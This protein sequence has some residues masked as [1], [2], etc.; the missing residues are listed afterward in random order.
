MA[1]DVE[2]E[3]REVASALER[4]EAVEG[5]SWTWREDAPEDVRENPPLGVVAQDLEKVFPELVSTR[6]DGFKQIN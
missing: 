3:L 6:P 2:R 5:V 4:L 1:D